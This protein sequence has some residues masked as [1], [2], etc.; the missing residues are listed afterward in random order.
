LSPISRLHNPFPEIL[1]IVMHESMAARQ[2]EGWFMRRFRSS[3]V[4]AAFILSL[5]LALPMPLLSGAAA[6]AQEVKPAAAAV[7]DAPLILFAAP[8]MD[9]HLLDTFT[10]EGAVPAL[11]AM[12][13]DGAKGHIVDAF[14]ATTGTSLPTLLSG[15]WPAEHGVV[16]ERFF[17]TGSP[18]FADWASWTDAGLVQADTLPQAAERAGKTVVSIGWQGVSGLDPAIAG[19]VVGDVIPFSE[20]GII[21]NTDLPDQPVT[22][23]RFGVAYDNVELKAADGWTGAPES[24]SPAQET[25][26][27]IPS[28]DAAGPNPDRTYAVYIYDS[29]DDGTTNYDQLLVA[30]DK[31]AAADGTQLSAGAW[32]AVPVTLTGERADQSAGFWL[33]AIAL[34]P[35]LSD[36]R[37]YYTPVSRYQAS[38]TGCGDR[39]ECQAPG[40]LEELLNKTLGPAIAI[41]AAPL[42]AGIIDEATFDAQGITS[43]WQRIDALRLIVDTLGIKPDLLLLESPFPSAITRQFLAQ[44]QDAE[45]GAATPVP[46]AADAT[47]KDRVAELQSYLR[48]GY[49]MADQL[50]AVGRGLLGPEATTIAVSPDGLAPSWQ[51][52]NAGQVLADAGLAEAAQPENCVPAA[53][54]APPG[55]PEPEALPV[56]PK[57]KAC[58]SGGTAHIYVNLDGREAA[59]SVAEDDYEAT[60]DAIVKAFTD[61]RDPDQPDATVVSGVYRKEELR[62]LGV[63]DALHP[64]RSGDVVVALSPPYRFDD[65]GSDGIGPATLRA[66][67]GYGLGESAGM[68]VMD[69]PQIAAGATIDARAIDVA[70]TA[71]FLLDVPGPYNASGSILF[72]ALANGSA[73]REITLLDISDFHGQLPPLTATADTI[74]A[75]GAVNSSYD[76]GG[77][78]VLGPWFDRYRAEATGPVYL[79]TAGDAVGATPPIST[80]FGD[81]PTIE[82]MNHLGFIA[83]SLGNHNFDAGADYMFGTLKP[84]ADYPYLSANLIPARADMATPPPAEAPFH[85]SLLL[86]EDDVSV[87]LVGFSNP[88]IPNLTR[89]GAL[90]PYRVIDPVAPV[91]DEAAKLRDEGAEVVIAMG[92]MG[93]TGGTLTEPTG[94]VVDMTD[95]L[96]GVDVVVAD[97]TDV[98]VSTVRPN[99]ILLVENRSKGVMFTRVRIVVD[100]ES[101]A[102]VYRTADFHRPW[103][104]GMTP[105]PAI[106]ERLEQLTAELAPTLGQVVGSSTKPI[107]RADSCGMETGRLCESLIGDIITDA[108]RFTYGTDFALINSGGIRADLTCPREGGDFCPSGG[109]RNQ[110][111]QGQVLTVLPFGNIAVTLQLSGAELKQMLEIGVGHMPEPSGGFPQVSG[112]CFTYDLKAE[113]GN[114]VTGAVRQAA[115]GTCTDE[116]IDLSDAATY[117]LTTNDFTAAGGDGYPNL[118]SRTNSRDILAQVVANSIAGQ[119]PLSLPGEP[120][121]PSIQGRIVCEGEGCPVPAPG[122]S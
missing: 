121:D 13:E 90:G 20:A 68:L 7:G 29:T 50:L 67:D 56:G 75:E 104:I 77:V 11:A 103:V 55:T 113:P 101:G 74:D 117:T 122:G 47:A 73:L 60:R 21:T 1:P 106:V 82:I 76:V 120:L 41:D 87:G 49:G 78:A 64:S 26:L 96:H 72:D 111:S 71:A 30:A 109:E 95:Q 33:K 5:L 51:A 100:S 32:A 89:P 42:D 48:D 34:A 28:L 116:A 37:L 53:V 35:D 59:G 92:H 79:L 86:A 31:T 40:G 6:R 17:R 108:M 98:Q 54:S 107:P 110:I 112:L 97:H 70:P 80:A 45:L 23:E 91:D 58:W 69:G 8:G 4:C 93:A 15:A 19:P 105:D 115:D 88:D 66:V 99:G 3:A 9:H 65:A 84:L 119:S 38:W 18:D 14:P 61:L 63:V 83:D 12:Q 10:A 24:Y 25:T 43:S 2:L 57:V 16:G 44:L 118:T 27:T 46:V 94:P 114:R 62:N 52:V 22:A 81:V 36:F 85:P 102:L 39:P